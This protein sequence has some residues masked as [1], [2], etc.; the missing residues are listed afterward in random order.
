MGQW[1]G[2]ALRSTQV[3]LLPPPEHKVLIHGAPH[4]PRRE[5]CAQHGTERTAGDQPPT[6]DERLK[7][8]TRMSLSTRPPL[9]V[10]LS[11]TA[12]WTPMVTPTSPHGG[13]PALPLPAGAEGGCRDL[14]MCE[15]GRGAPT[16]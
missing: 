14:S 11:V 7:G 15:A 12:G 1:P 5:A 4:Q 16:R 9:G 3:A 13:S 2:A 6:R 8:Q 10:R